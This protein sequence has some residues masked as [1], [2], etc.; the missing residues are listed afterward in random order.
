MAAT[1]ASP[2]SASA[3]ATRRGRQTL[4]LLCTIAFLDFADASIV[5]IAL[6]T[7]RD[8]LGFSL[9]RLTWV[10]SA[11]LLTYGGF[12]LLCGR[13]TVLIRR[14]RHLPSRPSQVALPSL[15]GALAQTDPHLSTGPLL[16][17]DC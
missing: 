4:A 8:D 6:P 2:P 13:A 12:M 3:L 17:G 9:Q 15:L 11:Y 7:I 14:P 10:P 16:H 1:T 5:N